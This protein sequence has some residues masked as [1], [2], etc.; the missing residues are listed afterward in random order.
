MVRVLEESESL[1][2]PGGTIL[3]FVPIL[4]AR[5][6]SPEYSVS[7]SLRKQITCD[8]RGR[9]DQTLSLRRPKREIHFVLPF[10]NLSGHEV[11]NE[12]VVYTGKQQVVVSDI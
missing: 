6:N 5:S 10:D 1:L 11:E 2:L 7:Q 9:A 3:R 12:V 8:S 4:D